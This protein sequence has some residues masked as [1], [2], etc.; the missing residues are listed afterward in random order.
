MSGSCS[1]SRWC[2]HRQLHAR[3]CRNTLKHAQ[4][5]RRPFI[6]TGVRT[7]DRPTLSS[8]KWTRHFLQYARRTHAHISSN[9]HA[10]MNEP[11]CMSRHACCVAT[12][13]VA[14][15]AGAVGWCTIAIAGAAAASGSSRQKQQQ[16]LLVAASSSSWMPAC[17]LASMH[18]CCWLLLPLL[19]RAM[20]CAWTGIHEP[21]CILL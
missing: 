4:V 10:C 15:A 13:V 1:R 17:M 21:V 3:E 8:A 12:V 2:A 20:L 7:F 11:V 9:W 5:V 6:K 19:L 18:G 14:G 16:Q